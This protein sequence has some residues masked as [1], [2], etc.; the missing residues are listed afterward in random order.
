MCE[1]EGRQAALR[2]LHVQGALV[3]VPPRYLSQLLSP[4]LLLFV[5]VRDRTSRRQARWRRWSS[6]AKASTHSDRI[7]GRRRSGQDTS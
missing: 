2:A 4:L 7:S 6:V 3:V 1:R 5:R